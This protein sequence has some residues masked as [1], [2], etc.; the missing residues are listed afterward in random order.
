MSTVSGITASDASLISWQEKIKQF[1]TNLEKLAESL[2]SGDI[3]AA[4]D[5]FSVLVQGMSSN[6]NPQ[7]NIKSDFDALGKALQSGDLDAAK[8]A[9]AK[10]QQDMQALRKTHRH[11]HKQSEQANT[12]TETASDNSTTDSGDSVNTL[13]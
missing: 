10:L 12:D 5:A 7:D 4:Q 1:K 11:H 3:S 9:F 13:A 8:K 2:Q 6:N